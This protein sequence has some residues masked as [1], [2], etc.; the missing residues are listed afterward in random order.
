MKENGDSDMDS[1]KKARLEKKGY[2]VGDA[3]DFL[4]LSAA[5]RK[6]VEKRVAK[7]KAKKSKLKA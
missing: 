6:T 3:G 4:G 1:K 2:A 5:E 7:A